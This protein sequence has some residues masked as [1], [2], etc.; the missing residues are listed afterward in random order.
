MNSQFRILIFVLLISIKGNC[1]LETLGKFYAEKLNE[2]NDDNTTAIYKI[3]GKKYEKNNGALFFA[4]KKIIYKNKTND[5]TYMMVYKKRYIFI[6][7]FP[8]TPEEIKLP[9]AYW[10]RV[11]NKL[12]VIDLEDSSKKWSYQFDKK[13]NIK[14]I[15]PKDGDITYCNHLKPEKS[16]Q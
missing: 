4:D 12:D 7:Y 10:D 9:F 14:K 8:N 16:N 1:Q 5:V 3:K 2:K 13:I 11:L 6:G 15:D